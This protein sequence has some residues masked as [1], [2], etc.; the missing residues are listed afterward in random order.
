MRV[1]AGSKA[2]PGGKTVYKNEKPAIGGGPRQA[3]LKRLR[4][5]KL[6]S[7]SALPDRIRKSTPGVSRGGR[8]AFGEFSLLAPWGRSVSERPGADLQPLGCGPGH[9]TVDAAQGLTTGLPLP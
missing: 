3:S 1:V 4:E 9:L 5:S 6:F 8:E 2:G 7:Y